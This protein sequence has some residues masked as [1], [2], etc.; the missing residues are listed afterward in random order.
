MAHGQLGRRSASCGSAP[1]R[2]EGSVK[3]EVTTETCVYVTGSVLVGSGDGSTAATVLQEVAGHVVVLNF[4]SAKNPGTKPPAW[5]W[6]P[7]VDVLSMDPIGWLSRDRSPTPS[8]LTVDMDAGCGG[9]LG[10]AQAQEESLARS[11]GLYPPFFRTD[12]GALLPRPVSCSVITSPA[13]NAGVVAEGKRKG[14]APVMQGRLRRILRLARAQQASTLIL[15][16][17]GCGVFRNAPQA[18]GCPGRRRWWVGRGAALRQG[19]GPVPGRLRAGRL[20]GAG[21]DDAAGAV[22]VVKPWWAAIFSQTLLSSAPTRIEPRWR[23]DG[24]YAAEAAVAAAAEA[25]DLEEPGSPQMICA[26]VDVLSRSVSPQSPPSSQLVSV[27]PDDDGTMRALTLKLVSFGYSR[28][29]GLPAADLVFDAR[30]IKNPQKGPQKYLTGLDARLR[31]E[32]MAN[33]GAEEFLEQILQDVRKGIEEEREMVVAVGCTHGK[34][35]PGG[36]RG[37]GWSVTFCE[38]VARALQKQKTPGGADGK[39][40]AACRWKYGIASA[41]VGPRNANKANKANQRN[42]ANGGRVAGVEV[43]NKAGGKG[44]GLSLG[45]LAHHEL[46]LVAHVSTGDDDD[47][48]D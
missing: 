34:H 40:A 21:R 47:E 30:H 20:R 9:F 6:L 31:K 11:S 28:Q 24:G 19:A 44:L 13:V 8:L 5:P 43:V 36:W 42:K 23:W 32:V 27:D 1:R 35:R 38:E 18:L 45:G 17:W 26:P 46:T 33:R 29:G 22:A 7:I 25:E 2:D 3:V 10:G 37:T 16:A 48:E 14:D 4:A 41:A 39:A 12:D 15:G